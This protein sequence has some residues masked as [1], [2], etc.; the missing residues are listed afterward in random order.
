M[1]FPSL[2]LAA[3]SLATP[4]LADAPR[5]VADTAPLHSLVARVMGEAGTPELLLPPG[6]SPHGANLRPSD[7]RRLS[8]AELVIWTGPA[9]LPWLDKALSTLAPEAERLALLESEGWARLPLR[10]SAAFGDHGGAAHGEDAHDDHDDHDDHDEAHEA[11]DQ[12]MQEH[13]HD[14]GHDHAHGDGTDPHAWLDPRVAAVWME[15]IAGALAELDPENAALYRSNAAEAAAADAALRDRLVTRL[16]PLAGRPYLVAHDA[17][18]YFETGFGLPA[19]GALALSDASAPGPARIAELRETVAAHGIGCVL[20]DP[21]T[22]AD[23]VALVEESGALRVAQTDPDGL[24]L[25]PGPDLY[26][27]LIEGLAEAI[28]GCLD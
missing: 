3:T 4:A 6:G 25:T 20:S 9:L 28:G 23:L 8:Q 26:P 19:A 15:K 11:H 21:E 13:G 22:P 7:A 24:H 10:E 12:D 2:L 5:V 1:R 14:H 16:A 17:Y 18:Q 27:T